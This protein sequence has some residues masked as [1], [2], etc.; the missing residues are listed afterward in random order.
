MTKTKFLYGAAVQG[1][2]SFIFQTDKL[3][4]MIGASELVEQICTSFFKKHVPSFNPDMLIVGAAGNIKYLFDDEN[5]CRQLVSRFPK[6]VME[7]APGVTISQAVVKISDHMTIDHISQLEDK[8]R[9]QRNKQFS[10]L[11]SGY[12][13]TERARRTGLAAIKFENK[14]VLD[15]RT[16]TKLEASKTSEIL[17][18]K[19]KQEEGTRLPFDFE[20]LAANTDKNWLAVIHA[21]GNGLG[22]VLQL[23][24]KA[25][26]G[27]GEKEIINA[28]QLFSMKLD[29]STI[30]A[31]EIAIKKTLIPFL[32]KGSKGKPDVIPFRPIIL[33]GDDLTIIVKSEYA[34]GFTEEFLRAFGQ[35]TERNLKELFASYKINIK[36][37][38]ACAG[39]AYIKASYPFHYGYD[40]AE[41][42]CSEAK[43]IAKKQNTEGVPACLMFHK[44]QASFVAN[45]KE[46]VRKE[47]TC[48][49]E[50]SFCYGPYYLEEAFGV[51][52]KW[53]NEKA[54]LLEKEG[55]P[56]AQLRRWLTERYHN[57]N[58]AAML[59][60]RTIQ[61]LG[62]DSNR[63]KYIA[64]LDLKE[65]LHVNKAKNSPYYD[66]VSMS[67]LIKI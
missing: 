43:T 47:L 46:I 41:Q 11:D 33:G 26:Q 6:L 2:Q 16:L 30:N 18:N 49:D 48:S 54:R 61:V 53:L 13:I 60:E 64:N 21:D 56:A 50:F 23:I 3:R 63:E 24:G 10:A 34:L 19:I 8:L 65:A 5:D 7:L 55:S 20:E 37:L 44:I 1:I 28:Y 42:L 52:I 4:E 36:K 38:T 58:K 27:N 32:M 22:K 9:T 39:I 51:S 14:E 31:A 12:L 40:L 45:Y 17:K 25:L 66:I 57:K 35:E 62:M 59:M 67:S 29:E 15:I